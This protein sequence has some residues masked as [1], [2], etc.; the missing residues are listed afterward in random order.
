MATVKTKY[1]YGDILYIKNDPD[2]NG[3]FFV[4]LIG[5]SSGTFYELSFLGELVEVYDFEVSDEKDT[6]KTLGVDKNESEDDG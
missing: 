5:R 4:G 6:L 1:K 3:Y 2:Q